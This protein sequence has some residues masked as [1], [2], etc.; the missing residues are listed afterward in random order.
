VAF[1]GLRRRLNDSV[2]ASLKAR[3]L[4]GRWRLVP[5]ALSLPPSI[6][7][8]PPVAVELSTCEGIVD[9]ALVIMHG[10]F[11]APAWIEQW[12]ASANHLGPGEPAHEAQH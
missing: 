8:P 7:L 1:K 12:S 10:A 11:S 3:K 6:L 9:Q 4:G 2:T 5:L